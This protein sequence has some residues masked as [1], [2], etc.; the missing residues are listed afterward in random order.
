MVEHPDRALVR[1]DRRGKIL[2]LPGDARPYGRR[3]VRV[4]P[5]GRRL[6][7]TVMTSTTGGLWV[8]DLESAM[9]TPIQMG[10]TTD[11]SPRGG[12]KTE[13]AWRSTGIAGGRRSLA[14]AHADG[15]G[16]PQV[17]ALGDLIPSSSTDDG[18]LAVV[19]VDDVAGDEVLLTTDEN[20]HARFSTLLG[21]AEN[22]R[23]P[24]LL[25]GRALAGLLLES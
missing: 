1:V 8:Y 13:G 24:G 17:I 10:G 4:A 5:D 25:A 11:V 20:G 6:A 19:R 15:S 21:P 23:E 9:L 2:L 16:A 3:T 7:V 22:S 14:W 12:R 18:N